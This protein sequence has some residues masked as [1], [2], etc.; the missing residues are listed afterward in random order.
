M[1]SF[2]G[3]IYKC[4]SRNFSV[5]VFII[6][7]LFRFPRDSYTQI[8]VSLLSWNEELS[9]FPDVSPILSCFQT[10][11]DSHSVPYTPAPPTIL[12]S[13]SQTLRP[14]SSSTPP[15]QKLQRHFNRKICFMLKKCFLAVICTCSLSFAFKYSDFFCS[16]KP[17]SQQRSIILWFHLLW[18]LELQLQSVAYITT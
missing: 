16:R 4:L 18:I 6:C 12:A 3:S 10:I 9:I 2:L 8:W 17:R 14:V 5:V 13:N 11:K 7:I 15:N 1:D